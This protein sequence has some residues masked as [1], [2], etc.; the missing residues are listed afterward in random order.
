MRIDDYYGFLAAKALQQLNAM[1]DA[2]LQEENVNG[3]LFG[4]LVIVSDNPGVTQR[5]AG[6]LQK[7]DRTTIGNFVDELCEGGYVERRRSQKDRRSYA[8]FLTSRGEEALGRFRGA[9]QQV[10]DQFF[11][12]QPYLLLEGE[13][14]L[15]VEEESERP[16]RAEVAVELVEDRTDIRYRTCRIVR[17]SIDEHGNPMRSI[18]L[19]R[20][21]L[22]VALVLAHRILDGTLDIVLRHI[23]TLASSD[24]GTKARVVLR[25]RTACLDGDGD[26]LA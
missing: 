14:R 17:Q 15:M 3:R 13:D 21:F 6:D 11:H 22:V 24:D 25:F 12:V 18:A 2:L 4:T 23:L 19:V 7:V 9:C 8:L 20:H 5:A 1:F 10:E 26:L 16:L